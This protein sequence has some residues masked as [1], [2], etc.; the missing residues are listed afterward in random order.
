MRLT[1]VVQVTVPLLYQGLLWLLPLVCCCV[2]KLNCAA[3]PNVSSNLMLCFWSLIV[4]YF[5]AST[6]RTTNLNILI[7]SWHKL[8][9]MTVFPA[10][11]THIYLLP[12]LLFVF[13]SLHGVTRELSSCWKT[14]LFAYVTSLPE[15]A[16]IYIF[17]KENGK[18]NSNAQ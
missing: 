13:V 9:I 2:C 8:K 15:T 7:F 10:K 16:K 18:N 6:D 1:F 5:D 3:T 14:W 12:P 11:K 4:G 17:T